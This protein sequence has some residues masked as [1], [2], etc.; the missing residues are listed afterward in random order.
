MGGFA[1]ALLAAALAVPLQQAPTDPGQSQ[2]RAGAQRALAE[3]TALIAKGTTPAGREALPL[4]DSAVRDWRALGDRLQECEALLQRAAAYGLL[5]DYAKVLEDA[6]SALHLARAL[7]DRRREARA[8]REMADGHLNADAHDEAIATLGMALAI[9]RELGDRVEEA[10]ALGALGWAYAYRGDLHKHAEIAR[11][12]RE[13]SRGLADRPGEAWSVMHLAGAHANVGD[14]QGALENF[15][16]AQALFRALGDRSSEG[17]ALQSLG[18]MHEGLGDHAS[19]LAVSEEALAIFLA[20]GNRVT[21]AATYLSMGRIRSSLGETRKA[22]EL[23]EKAMPIYRQLGIRRRE[24]QALGFIGAALNTLGEPEKAGAPLEEALRIAAEVNDAATEG[25]AHLTLGGMRAEAGRREEARAHFRRA[26]EVTR[27]Q[28]PKPDHAAALYR[29]ARL[30]RETGDLTE[31]RRQ[32]EAALDVLERI[33]RSVASPTLRSTFV[34]S[35]RETYELY[36]DVLMRLHAA[37]PGQGF[38]ARALEA[39]EAARARGLLDQLAEAGLEVRAG[40]DASLLEEE[41][42]IQLRLDA[43]L[44][45]QLRLAQAKP[46]SEQAQA[47]ARLVQTLTAE[48]DAARAKI[49]SQSPRFAE[50]RE[51]APATVAAIREEVLG[52]DTLLL[53]YA[54]GD[55]RSI[56]WVVG[57]DTLSTYTLPGRADVEKAAREAYAQLGDP[58]GSASEALARLSRMVLGPAAAA[59]TGKRLLV[60]ADGALH[61]VPFA[62]LPHPR[63]PDQPLL[64]RHEVVGAPSA[65]VIALLRREAR[66][67]VATKTLAVLADPVFDRSDE[68]LRGRAQVAAAAPSSASRR[69]LERAVRS[70]GLDG[71]LPRLPFTRRE[72][73]AILSLVP[74]RARRAALD[75]DASRATVT[76]TSLADFRLVHFATHGFLNSAQPGLSGVVL[77]LVDREGADARGFLT[78]TDVF[79][80]RLGADMVVL[81]GCRTALGQDLRGEGLLGLSRGFMYAGAPRVVS[82]L[83]K[84]DDAATAELMTRFYRGILKQRLPPGAALRAAQRGLARRP[85]FRHPFYWAAFQLQG[86]WR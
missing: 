2:L 9:R 80:L 19:A 60:V 25:V 20:D 67:R 43:A 14:Y 1:L 57:R 45:R 52:T 51:P 33:R 18:A 31:A 13:M 26:A 85:R 66:P 86:E 48:W 16:E 54:L 36:V 79:N 38:D 37:H 35:R 74:P 7:P 3:G 5:P 77:S 55:A 12:V 82:S 11:E 47:A 30:A 83:W 84:V 50:L 53:E 41:R 10:E 28:L 68:R 44:D 76:D 72:A 17:I 32:A 69:D 64:E 29:L 62:A 4:L 70:A 61:Y 27:S 8:L 15:R 71:G 63:R 81:S 24:A 49:R 56:L 6:S 73:E 58:A 46:D 22:L 59:L 23:F 21:E 42:L 34:A 39:S 75:F 40:V 65:S 78:A